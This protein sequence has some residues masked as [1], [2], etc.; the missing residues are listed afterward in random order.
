MARRNGFA[1]PSMPWLTS[2]VPLSRCSKRT[3]A[4]GP[5]S[6]ASLR[7]HG[8]CL[9]S[10]LQVASCAAR[11]LALTFSLPSLWRAPPQLTLRSGRPPR[12]FPMDSFL[13]PGIP[14]GMPGVEK[15]ALARPTR[16]SLVVGLL[17]TRRFGSNFAQDRCLG[18]CLRS[19]SP[20]RQDYATLGCP[21]LGHRI[22]FVPPRTGSVATA[23]AAQN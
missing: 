8:S 22:G 6:S 9:L 15:H 19:V 23:F 18:D 14:G 10:P 21:G 3:D 4:G 12:K 1:V 11:A 5:P 16:D 20:S 7:P 13:H 2:S 17:L